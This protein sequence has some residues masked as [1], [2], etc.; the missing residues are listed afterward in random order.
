MSAGQSV[1]QKTTPAEADAGAAGGTESS[2]QESSESPEGGDD[3]A[4]AEGGGV[5][6]VGRGGRAFRG[7]YSNLH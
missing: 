6:P 4:Q 3:N 5:Q 2:G 7:D 1:K